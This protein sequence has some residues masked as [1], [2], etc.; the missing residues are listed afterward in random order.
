[1]GTGLPFAA[2][3]TG[4]EVPLARVLRGNTT[5]N[6][7]YGTGN[8]YPNDVAGQYG[9]AYGGRL[10]Q[11]PITAPPGV[12]VASNSALFPNSPRP[13]VGGLAR[14]FGSILGT[15]YRSSYYRAPITYYRPVTAVD[16]ATGQP[17]VVQQACSSYEQQLRR[18]PFNQFNLGNGST[19]TPIG[20]PTL[21]SPGFGGGGCQNGS[22]GLAAAPG[23]FAQPFASQPFASQPF[24]NQGFANQPYP[25]GPLVPATGAVGQ[26][27]GTTSPSD[28]DVIRIPSL[29]PQGSGTRSQVPQG[30]GT[31]SEFGD[32]RAPLTGPPSDRDNVEQPRLESARPRTDDYY[33]GY[34]DGLYRGDVKSNRYERDLPSRESESR[35]RESEYTQ[36]R[37]TQPRE[38]TPP[39]PTES[40]AETRARQ[41]E[42]RYVEPKLSLIHIS[43]PTRP[44]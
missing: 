28:R 26:V 8:L 1:M 20:Q 10:G 6:P 36:P 14:F 27:G 23:T 41:A 34:A 21:V 25:V 42:S 7:F 33:R 9:A 30:S 13:Q 19:V 12:A 18:V 37:N 43:E 32:N 40:P 4:G 15:N 11:L 22:C 39:L 44:Y 16:P 35:Y 24:P 38:T 31:R 17:T 5:S 29:D 3:N 2:R